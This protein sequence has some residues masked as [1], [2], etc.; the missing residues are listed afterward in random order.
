MSTFEFHH[1]CSK[2]CHKHNNCTTTRSR[3]EICLIIFVTRSAYLDRQ[4]PSHAGQEGAV[5]RREHHARHA[6]E[7]R[8]G[9][10]WAGN[11][12]HPV[13]R[14]VTATGAFTAVTAWRLLNFERGHTSVV[15]DDHI[16]TPEAFG[17]AYLWPS[18]TNNS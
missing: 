6:E 12:E 2:R 1:Q 15:L 5:V 7:R 8:T 18:T 14:A 17:T 13:A 4:Q 3:I 9:K 16:A 10:P 11:T